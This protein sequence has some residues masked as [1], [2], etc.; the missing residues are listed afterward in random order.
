[1]RKVSPPCTRSRKFGIKYSALH[2]QHKKLRDAFV[3]V[4]DRQEWEHL[5]ATWY[6]E[7]LPGRYPRPEMHKGSPA[8]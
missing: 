5:L 8:V 4:R 7:D 6:A 2:P 3:E 1:M